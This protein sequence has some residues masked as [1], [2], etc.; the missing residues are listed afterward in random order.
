MFNYYMKNITFDDPFKKKN[1]YN[2]EIYDICNQYLYIEQLYHHEDFEYK[3]I[4]LKHLKTK[5][6]SYKYQDKLKKKFD[7]DKYITFEELIYKLYESKLKCYYCKTELF[8][9]YDNKKCN[10]QWSL[11][12]LNNNLGH[13]KNNTCISCLKCNLQRRNDNHEYFK[14]S[15]Q[16]TIKKI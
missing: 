15:K 13:Y 11:E 1:I 4:I 5:Y 6:N 8:L 12:R 9:M 14:F 3:P 10:Q 2:K 16:L 7:H